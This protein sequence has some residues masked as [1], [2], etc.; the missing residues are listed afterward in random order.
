MARRQG[1]FGVC[2]LVLATSAFGQLNA[3]AEPVPLQSSIERN[4]ST[5]SGALSS[6]LREI[7]RLPVAVD[8]LSPDP[9]APPQI[10]RVFSGEMA[11]ELF[12]LD[13]LGEQS[14]FQLRKVDRNYSTL[15]LLAFAKS[16][17][18][19]ERQF[20][21][22]MLG[23]V[24][25]PSAIVREAI[26]AGLAD[27]QELVRLAALSAAIRV[28]KSI[29][30]QL[31][32]KL[33]DESVA[34]SMPKRDHPSFSRDDAGSVDIALHD[35]A[36]IALL[37]LRDVDEGPLWRLVLDRSAIVS[38]PAPN[39][40]GSAEQH[41]SASPRTVADRALL[42]LATRGDKLDQT[43]RRL[44]DD[45]RL[46][47]RF[48]ATMVTARS[49]DNTQ[50]TTLLESRVDDENRFVRSRA[51]E[52]L[53]QAGRAGQALLLKALNQAND[54]VAASILPHLDYE[55]P[56][57][58]PILRGVVLR[59]QG[60]S[61]ENFAAHIISESLK[62][63][64]DPWL[65]RETP[66]ASATRLF[67]QQMTLSDFELLAGDNPLDLGS[68]A[69]LRNTLGELR[70]DLAT[71][72]AALW[73]KSLEDWINSD[74]AE[75]LS[76]GFET[77]RQELRNHRGGLD[78][79]YTRA[80]PELVEWSLRE[81]EIWATAKE[82]Y[83]DT[84]AWDS[85]PPG[86]EL[87]PRFLVRTIA[88]ARSADLVSSEQDEQ[89]FANLTAAIAK[90]PDQ[91]DYGFDDKPSWQADPTSL[92]SE[93]V[94]DECQLFQAMWNRFHPRLRQ[95]ASVDGQ[96]IK[97]LAA[98][99]EVS[100]YT[101]TGQNKHQEIERSAI[102]IARSLLETSSVN[103]V[104]VAALSL[105]KLLSASLYRSGMGGDYFY[106]RL[107][108]D[109][110]RR[111]ISAENS[112]LAYTHQWAAELIRIATDEQ[113]LSR[114][115]RS[116]RD[117][118]LETALQTAILISPDNGFA[119]REKLFDDKSSLS[120]EAAE[121]LWNVSRSAVLKSGYWTSSEHP[122]MVA[123]RTAIIGD[124]VAA[125]RS[126]D[127]LLFSEP[128]ISKLYSLFT[129]AEIREALLPA[130]VHPRPDRSDYYERWLWADGD[131][132]VVLASVN[133]E[134]TGGECEV[135]LSAL[136]RSPEGEDLRRDLALA[137]LQPG[138]WQQLPTESQ[139]ADEVMQCLRFAVGYA[140]Q[141]GE[142]ERALLISA[143]EAGLPL[144]AFSEI[145]EE[146]SEVG[147]TDSAVLGEHDPLRAAISARLAQANA[148]ASNLRDIAWLMF[149]NYSLGWHLE[150]R[151]GDD[152]VWIINQAAEAGGRGPL[153]YLTSLLDADSFA[154]ATMKSAWRAGHQ[155][156]AGTQ[157]ARGRTQKFPLRSV[158]DTSSGVT[159][160]N[161]LQ[162]PSLAEIALPAID[163]PPPAGFR[164]AELR[165]LTEM[166][167]GRDQGA[168]REAIVQAIEGADVGF[169]WGL[170]R[171]PPR[172]FAIVARMEQ[173]DE[174]GRPKPGRQRWI[175]SEP[176][177]LTPADFVADLFFQKPGYYRV[178]LFVVS[179]DNNPAQG[180]KVDLPEPNEGAR[181]LP[182]EMAARPIGE[183]AVLALIYNFERRRN[184][185]I[186]TWVDS[187]SARSQLASAGLEEELE[188]VAQRLTRTAFAGAAQAQ[189]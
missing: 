48:A 25:R 30:P 136:R 20:A 41:P 120:G 170:F 157:T 168:A 100:P 18:A 74:I 24:E 106:E 143:V 164:V 76:L 142:A 16:D 6:S 181:V 118:E 82:A 165:Q 98:F 47:V 172:G 105:A 90:N 73:A 187:P 159:V 182:A 79:K 85:R 162:P 64:D 22:T 7:R 43:T 88:Q 147:G 124:V 70:P 126:P 3:R 111:P 135:L 122:R 37:N 167:S 13:E 29:Q 155:F 80:H 138:S 140:L 177:K 75:A 53:A 40:N 156:V 89:I 116:A 186:T 44:I 92:E 173:V 94:S 114:E 19:G 36:L 128:A 112:S 12:L 52:G 91:F 132:G 32:E 154:L 163:W 152:L 23:D 21:M 34:F 50:R 171:G 69:I 129:D 59:A 189:R 8:V 137:W 96:E 51:A 145:D 93:P 15:E 87:T 113:H 160:T 65:L 31:M 78:A 107:F 161:G 67:V 72:S 169:E 144:D 86:T 84:R 180:P 26:V 188:R 104:D 146:Y 17:D 63:G 1:L 49:P 45:K 101:C 123:F 56:N 61:R 139:T 127:G 71:Q 103:D 121:L 9:E 109:F 183:G 130:I 119:L 39:K 10:E 115:V 38:P 5:N 57:I 166:L 35:V 185:S 83:Q 150:Q 175:T 158:E 148:E 174:D 133:R 141:G 81:L 46:R 77:G 117:W 134:L 66:P 99:L 2:T 14:Y 58:L 179:D 178:V 54:E 60:E 151:D 110:D 62:S 176:A 4:A 55:A 42:I 97:A 95:N 125:I 102:E 27:E 68:G 11:W 108:E 28:G 184:A 153:S 131:P 33:G 149:G